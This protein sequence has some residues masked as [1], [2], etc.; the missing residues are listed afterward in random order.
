MDEFL[1]DSYY[2]STVMRGKS[3]EGRIGL[4]A[5]PNFFPGRRCAKP[6]SSCLYLFHLTQVRDALLWQFPV[7]SQDARDVIENP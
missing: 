1:T 7:A 6:F 2:I 5:A 4:T 3:R